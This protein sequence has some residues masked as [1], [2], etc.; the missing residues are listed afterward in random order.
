LKS[1]SIGFINIVALI[2]DKTM[3]SPCSPG[4]GRFTILLIED[5]R[6]VIDML[7]RAAKICFPE[8]D[9]VSITTF[10]EAVLYLFSLEGK[11]P[12]LIL[13]DVFF[14]GLQTGL[15]FLKLLKTDPQGKFIPVIVLS[16]NDNEQQV[17]QAYR[18]G[19]AS[20]FVKPFSFEEWKVFMTNLRLFWFQTAT[21]PLTYFERR[22]SILRE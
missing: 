13:V 16:A 22:V 10:E 2:K 21:L 6:V 18:E 12:Q 15:D 4:S 17:K 1:K 7:Q 5:D 3:P 9:Y 19:A 14:S 20:Y 11:G 8:A